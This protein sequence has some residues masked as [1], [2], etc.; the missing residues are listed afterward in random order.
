MRHRGLRMRHP[1][2]R[3]RFTSGARFLSPCS[4]DADRSFAMR[5]AIGQMLPAPVG[6]AISPLPFVA[7]VLMLMGR[8]GRANRPAFALG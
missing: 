2:G 3:F 5:E 8:R 4:Y 6:V 7:V 1:R